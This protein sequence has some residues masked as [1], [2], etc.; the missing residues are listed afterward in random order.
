MS[1]ARVGGKPCVMAAGV[2]YGLVFVAV[3]AIYCASRYSD[4]QRYFLG[5]PVATAAMI[6]GLTVVAPMMFVACY[7][8]NFD[9]W[10]L[11]PDD[12]ERFRGMVA[13]REAG[14]S[15]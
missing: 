1:I 13:A 10:I 12:L 6:Y 4:Q 3:I 7:V 14:E 5:Y 9:R 15:D 2:V 11:S 8:R